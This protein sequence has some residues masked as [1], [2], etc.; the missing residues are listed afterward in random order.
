MLLKAT[1]A[2]V[3]TELAAD[4]LERRRRAAC[5]LAELAW[6][7]TEIAPAGSLGDA[8]ARL[9]DDTDPLLRLHGVT[10]VRLA[11]LEPRLRQLE[12]TETDPWV[13]FELSWQPPSLGGFRSPAAQ[14]FTEEPPF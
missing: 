12:E 5:W 14:V 2:D 11:G 6:R 10:V 1:L 13:R 7:N 4:D 3:L 8:A 9:L